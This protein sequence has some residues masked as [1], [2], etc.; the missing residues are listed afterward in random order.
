MRLGNGLLLTLKQRAVK[1]P[2]GGGI[3][4]QLLQL[5]LHILGFGTGLVGFRQLR[6]NI[7]FMGAGHL[8]LAR[9]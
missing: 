2:A 3:L 6:L 4:R 5:R 1:R 9:Q 7:G 8:Q